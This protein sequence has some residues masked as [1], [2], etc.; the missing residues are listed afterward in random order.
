MIFSIDTEKHL[1]KKSAYFPDE[2]IKL[3]KKETTPT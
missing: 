2:K 3:A 1:K